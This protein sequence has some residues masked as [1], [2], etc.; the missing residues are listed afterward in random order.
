MA[1]EIVFQLMGTGRR[2]D[3]AELLP[4]RPNWQQAIEFVRNKLNEAVDTAPAR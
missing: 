2:E 3:F 1:T 4:Q